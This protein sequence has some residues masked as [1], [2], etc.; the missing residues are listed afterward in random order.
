MDDRD[1]LAERPA[2]FRAQK[3]MNRF[4]SRSVT[5]TPA[6]SLLRRIWV[7]VHAPGSSVGGWL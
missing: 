6:D 2:K 5:G 3:R 7:T 1:V 4:F